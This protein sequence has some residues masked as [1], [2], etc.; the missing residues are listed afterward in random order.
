M[1]H[2]T[3]LRSDPSAADLNELIDFS[4]VSDVEVTVDGLRRLAERVAELNP[5][6]RSYKVA[7]VA[8][9]DVLFGLT[10]LYEVLNEAAPGEARAFRSLEEAT[11]WLASD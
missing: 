7:V 10:R 3:A 11:S 4:D 1:S 6:G 8:P 9:S 2:A 5:T